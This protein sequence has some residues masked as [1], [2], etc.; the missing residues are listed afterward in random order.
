[1]TE[2]QFNGL[3]DNMKWRL[4]TQNKLCLVLMFNEVCL[5]DL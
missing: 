3:D 1:M 4:T 2:R 5:G